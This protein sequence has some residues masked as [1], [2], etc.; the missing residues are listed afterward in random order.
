MIA[1]LII[2]LVVGA[3]KKTP[4]PAKSKTLRL[5]MLIPLLQAKDNKTQKNPT[6]SNSPK[7]CCLERS[8]GNLNNPIMLKV[9]K[10][11]PTI[12]K[13][14]LKQFKIICNIIKLPPF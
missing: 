5:I 9:Q 2:R 4:N 13:N 8:P 11:S 1:A 14:Q 3:L 7:A 10:N 6:V 12:I